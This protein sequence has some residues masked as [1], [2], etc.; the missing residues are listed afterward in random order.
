M[1]PREQR[2]AVAKIRRLVEESNAKIAHLNRVLRERGGTQGQ[3]AVL[4]R[5]EALI[6]RRR[7]M[8]NDLETLARAGKLTKEAR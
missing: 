6:D 2:E 3:E 8:M 5:L 7:L 1:T 4:R